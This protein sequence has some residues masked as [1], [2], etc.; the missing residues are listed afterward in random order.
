MDILDLRPEPV[1]KLMDEH[2]NILFI[3]G[4]AFEVPSLVAKV[5]SN[6]IPLAHPWLVS[7]DCHLDSFPLVTQFRFEVLA[8]V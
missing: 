5:R 1:R 4:D 6:G 3:Q 2:P 8:S 7:E